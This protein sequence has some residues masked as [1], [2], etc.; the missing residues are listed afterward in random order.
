MH[1]THPFT[2]L[3]RR[4][5]HSSRQYRHANDNSESLFKPDQGFVHA[6]DVAAVEKA[7]DEYENTLMADI[8]PEDYELSPEEHIRKEAMMMCRV[9]P[10][11]D[12]RNFAKD[13]LEY[14]EGQEIAMDRKPVFALR[15]A[16]PLPEP[17]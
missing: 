15:V 11:L 4:I 10:S 1:Q 2:S 16:T 3:R 5:R 6:Y 7:L 9:H 12:A 13:V 14:L 17:D 8:A